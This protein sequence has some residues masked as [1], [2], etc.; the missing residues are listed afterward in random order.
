MRDLNWAM[1]WRCGCWAVLLAAPLCCIGLSNVAAGEDEDEDTG[2]LIARYTAN[3]QTIRRLDRDVQFVWQDDSPD[4]RLPAGAFRV[5]WNGQLLVRAAGNYRISLYMQGDASVAVNGKQVLSAAHARPAWAS[6]DEIELDFGEQALQIR[7]QKTAS[8][9]QIRLYW[10]SDLF[11]IEPIPVQVL[12]HDTPAPELKTWERG[13][14]LYNAARCNR[15]HA[16][17][18]EASAA[19]APALLNVKQDLRPDWLIDWLASP[20]VRPPPAMMP[21]FGFSRSEAAAVSDY[22]VS[23]SSALRPPAS[24]AA[25]VAGDSRQG[26]LLVLSRG[27]L[28]CH[29]LSSQGAAGLFGGGD[30]TGIDRKRPRDWLWTW[31]AEPDRLNPDHRMPV[32]PFSEAERRQVTAFLSLPHSGENQP[33]APQRP[34]PAANGQHELGR[35]LVEAARCVACHH[36]PQ[37]A[38]S[39]A[40]VASLATPNLDWANSCV[41]A[42]PDRLRGR[43]AYRFA[44]A[45]RAALAA[46]VSSQ[47]RPL[48][49]EGR[50]DAGA[51]LLR[52][53]NCINC[54]ERDGSRGIAPVAGE[55]CRKHAELNG[56]SEALLPPDLTAVGDKLRDAALAEAIVGGQRRRLPWLRVTMPRFVHRKEDQAALVAH[57]IGHDR[58]PDDPPQPRQAPIEKSI[59]PAAAELLKAGKT[60]VGPKGFSCVACHRLGRF[61]PR[62]VALG[63]RG[64]DLVE[65]GTRMRPEYF[66][67]WTRSPLRIV[68][69]MEM[70]S[71]E[72]P[73]AGVLQE[74]LDLQLQ[75]LWK[76]FNSPQAGLPENLSIVERT[77]SPPPDAPP[78]IIRDVMRDVASPEATF[79]PRAFAVG[80]GNGHNLLFDLDQMAV[81]QWW[82]GDLAHQVTQGKSWFWEPAGIGLLSPPPP[83]SD[84]VLKPATG[85]KIVAPLSEEG[86]WGRLESYRQEN[87]RIL[88]DYQLKFRVGDAR[89][90]ALRVHEELHALDDESSDK[91]SG[92]QRSI[93]VGGRP[94]DCDVVVLQ[95]T[96]KPSTNVTILARRTADT[97]P[98]AR[99]DAAV[100]LQS[101][102]GEFAGLVL[103]ARAQDRNELVTASMTF[104][105]GDEIVHRGAEP[106]PVRTAALERLTVVPGYDGVRLPLDQSIMPTAIT[107]T[108]DGTLAF[109]SLRGQVYLARD[110]NGDGVEDALTVFEDG[111]AAPYGLITDGPDLIVAHK[112]ELLRLR[113]TNGDGRADVREVVAAGWGYTDNYH[114]WTFGIVR[115][116]HQNLYFGLGSDYAQPGRRRETAKWRGKVLRVAPGGEITPLGHAFR[117]PTGLAITP[118][119]QVFVT[120]N[121][122]V[123]NTFNEIN[124]LVAGATYGVPSLFEEP[125]ADPPRNPAIQIPHPWTRSVNGIFFLPSSTS[126]ATKPVR[127]ARPDFGPLSGHGIG[128]EYDSRFLV[129]F[130]LQPVGTTY[131]GAVYA[132]SQPPAEGGGG[133]FLGTL[134]GAVSPRGE[135]YVG[136]LDDSG[137]LGG[138]NVGDLVRLTPNGQLPLGI[139]EVRATP[140]GFTISF[141]AAVDQVAAARPENYTIACY[142]RQ[143]QGAYATPDSGRR[144]VKIE[145]VAATHDGL[146]VALDVDRLQ[147]NFVYE[148]TCGRIGPGAKTALQPATAYYTLNQFVPAE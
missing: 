96:P 21:D 50:F 103:A 38:T 37:I 144:Q 107:W 98:Q 73:V 97:R 43:P 13:R 34:Q 61:E 89:L 145:R 8:A 102:S 28:A 88:I 27:C 51:R 76:L 17:Q 100:R 92:W 63:T 81:R 138:P 67:R 48:S 24:V 125:H 111:L 74:N 134:C 142:T 35:R 83:F 115:D 105:A 112:P 68:P 129:R 127:I 62:N 60:L 57:L 91:R 10:S 9:A 132:F 119:D 40:K 106:P 95:P 101:D 14:A 116:S 124:H 122:G 86:R 99:G 114:D 137:W 126:S 146:S 121:Q 139:R 2:G 118:D 131:Q 94:A 7:F 36:I 143:W 20:A 41:Q 79:T 29:T 128:C 130:T 82:R 80:F 104:V 90:I 47:A 71:Y 31:L 84:I 22:L 75:S 19:P 113:D 5:E 1:R 78:V 147:E 25:A 65:L 42:G 6:S 77:V 45:D 53:K 39:P 109:C 136:S 117:Y 93:F 66:K 49:A 46:Y 70:P 85:D 15:C 123:A 16:R 135:I 11:P 87:G 110:T 26:E 58:I 30:L 12:F 141:T 59:V 64:S 140:R 120:D 69:G 18:D 148:V 56:L 55:V 4:P 3:T 108:A 32:F 72:R 54:H 33:P 23:V 133:R 52:E 44:E